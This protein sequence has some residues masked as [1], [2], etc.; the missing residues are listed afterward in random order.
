MAIRFLNRGLRLINIIQFPN[1]MTE[2]NIDH[3]NCQN[4]HFSE[5]IL[6][7]V[8]KDGLYILRQTEKM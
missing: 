8:W 2:L 3:E 5:A 4:Q 7:I 6:L 1:N